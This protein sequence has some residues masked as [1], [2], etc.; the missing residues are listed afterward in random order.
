[1]DENEFLRLSFKKK[2]EKVE[3]DIDKIDQIQFK[4]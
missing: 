1:L 3:F 2:D 4:K